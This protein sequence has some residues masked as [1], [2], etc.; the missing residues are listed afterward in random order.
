[1]PL[2]TDSSYRCPRLLSN[3]HLQTLWPNFLRRVRPLL[4]RRERIQT[5]DGDFLDLD[6]AQKGSQKIAV[7]S[8]GLEGDS[9]R[10]Y[11]L[12]MVVA[13]VKNGWDAVSWNAR[14]CS[15][16]TNRV[17]RFTQSGATEDLHT[18]LSHV[19]SANNYSRIALIGFS[20][21]GNLTL[22]YLGERSH[23]LDSRIKAAVAFSVP[24]DLQAGSI[25]L[26]KPMNWIYMQRFLV[27]LYIKI[28]A[29]MKV[30]P[31]KIDDRGYGR[32]RN[33]KDFD[34]RYTAPI[35][36]FKDAEDYWRKCSCKQFLENIRVP[37]L[38]VNAG[39]DPFLAQECYPVEEARENS[40][41]HL[42]IPSTG[43]H[44]GFGFNSGGEY[45][46]ETRAVP[47]LSGTI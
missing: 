15:G 46:S 33:F 1:M 40:C 4:Y 34:D 32:L 38:L 12:G 29:M 11:M 8:H 39:N 9:K 44:V 17:L 22:K 25:Q 6:W 23:E 5:P 36:G 7:L 10:H 45:W 30:V 13:L 24:C 47:F 37:T 21:G 27:S 18:V 20:L 43:G 26:A 31:G 14:G 19:T 41:L 42:E 2:I 35:H 28:R 16:E 3:G